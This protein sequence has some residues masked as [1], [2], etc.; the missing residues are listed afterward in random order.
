M[1]H[2]LGVSCYLCLE[3]PPTTPAG[4][5]RNSSSLIGTRHILRPGREGSS[6]CWEA[7]GAGPR[8]FLELGEQKSLRVIGSTCGTCC[9]KLKSLSDSVHFLGLRYWPDLDLIDSLRWRTSRV[10]IPSKSFLGAALATL[11]EKSTYACFIIVHVQP[12]SH[13][14]VENFFDFSR[15]SSFNM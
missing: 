8:Q 14:L 2:S 12:N 15:Q 13:L 7:E 4:M 1:L 5:V 11:P 6:Y 3:C 9:S 10:R